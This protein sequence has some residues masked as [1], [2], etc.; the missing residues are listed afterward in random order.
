MSTL[1]EVVLRPLFELLFLGL[2]FQTGKWVVNTLIPGLA[3]EP[4][5]RGPS[6]TRIVTYKKSGKRYIAAEAAAVVGMF[7][8][9]LVAL[10]IFVVRS[11]V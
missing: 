3:V 1:L 2:A 6:D 10:V 5:G 8:W 4:F 11:A 7:A 9:A